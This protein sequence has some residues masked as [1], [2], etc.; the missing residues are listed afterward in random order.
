MLGTWMSF[1]TKLGCLPKMARCRGESAELCS[2]RP[3]LRPGPTQAT[4]PHN[5]L[6]EQAHKTGGGQVGGEKA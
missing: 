1:T 5:M 6:C 4:Q 2:A 3:G